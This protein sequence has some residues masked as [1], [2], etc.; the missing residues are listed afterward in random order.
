MSESS[1]D[2]VDRAILS[3]LHRDARNNTN[4]AIAE[5][6]D[7]ATSTVSKRIN[8]L[9]EQGIIKGYRPEIDYEQVGLP[10]QVLFIC[11]VPITEREL[12]IQQAVDI[13][14]VVN[15]RELMTGQQNVHILVAAQSNAEITKAAHAIDGLGFTVTDEILL[16]DEDTQPPV[17]FISETED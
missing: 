17:M 15:I 8:R 10:L 3:E 12:L 13:D 4:A 14:T 5:Q 16:R 1:L 9:E 2:D 7:M 11:T 6:I